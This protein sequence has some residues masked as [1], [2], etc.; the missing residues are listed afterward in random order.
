MDED[1]L[2]DIIGQIYDAA[3]DQSLWPDALSK[4]ADCFGAASCH[5]LIHDT[6]TNTPIMH[7]A[8]TDPMRI[9]E[10]FEYYAQKNPWI[11]PFLNL[12]SGSVTPDDRIFPREALRHT[13]FFNDH[14]RT[15]KVS[16]CLGVLVLNT[17][18]LISSVTI[19][20]TAERGEFDDKAIAVGR[21][22]LP[23]FQRAIQLNRKLNLE[24]QLGG[25]AFA[26][27]D[28]VPYGVILVKADS[29]VCHANRMA[30]SI[31]N[32]R[33]GLSIIGG[34]L[35]ASLER[36]G[37]AIRRQIAGAITPGA[38][39]AGP[40]AIAVSRRSG[41]RP[42]AVVI[43]PL[44]TDSSGLFGDVTPRAV[45]FV[46]DP[47]RSA[48]AP[49]IAL[50]RIYGLTAR[51]AAVTSLLVKGH[52]LSE[53]ADILEIRLETA[54]SH[55]KHALAKTDT[56]RQSDLVRLVLSSAARLAED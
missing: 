3:L 51:E 13:E 37:A 14:L 9:S 23:H 27:L 4:V 45:V 8:R 53:A 29:K 7:L 21:K 18:S 39:T 46:T 20:R 34:E 12:P 19:Y 52:V 36:D 1:K 35:H 40:A 30:E 54:R 15:R 10:Y 42:F 28:R 17:P 6:I 48:E 24:E 22:L 41:L 47:E 16:H 32:Q 31:L 26:A 56:S 33:D 2:L 5:F 11:S 55:L 50:Q 44:R 25:S 38:I 49:S 43:S